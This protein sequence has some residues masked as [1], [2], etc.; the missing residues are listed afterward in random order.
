MRRLLS[1]RTVLGVVFIVSVGL[2]LDLVFS[3]F[4]ARSL[5]LHVKTS[6]IIEDKDMFLS[7]SSSSAFYEAGQKASFYIDVVNRRDQTIR[8]IDYTVTV[9]ALWYL[10]VEVF[11]MEGS[12]ERQEKGGYKPGVWERLSI[13]KSLPELIPPGLYALELVAKPVGMDATG[14]A[15]IIIYVRPS[16]S[17]LQC[18]MLV[19]IISGAALALSLT[20]G[21]IVRWATQL[22]SRLRFPRVPLRFLRAPIM[23][24]ATHVT[25]ARVELQR[26]EVET[27]RLIASFSIGQKFVFSGICL[28]MLA[29]F[30]LIGGLEAFASEIATLTYFALVIGVL[31][32]IWDNIL[33]SR[34]KLRQISKKTPFY[35]RVLI[36][37]LA[38]S[39]LIY[40][41]RPAISNI[42]A[43]IYILILSFTAIY[44]IIREAKKK[45]T[46]ER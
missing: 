9:R 25:S 43:A 38:F 7:F 33:E 27:V 11:R 41:S 20:G 42:S 3:D 22:E 24:A 34:P 35:S 36:N 5:D 28:L 32:L 1:F 44:T 8:R 14:P 39:V 18:S 21:L 45:I 23:R 6:V 26:I 19:V 17:H 12:S 2:S 40:L 46:D 4:Q 37:L 13:E 29:A 31:N 30:M 15:T 10:G 16:P